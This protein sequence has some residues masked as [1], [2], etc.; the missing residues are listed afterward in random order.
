MEVV[1]MLD[2]DNNYNPTG[3]EPC[4]GCANIWYDVTYATIKDAKI[5]PVCLPIHDT[6]TILSH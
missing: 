5:C 6:I 3:L 4:V 2:L 1:H